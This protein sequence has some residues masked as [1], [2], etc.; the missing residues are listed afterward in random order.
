MMKRSDVQEAVL[1][2]YLRLNGYFTTGFI[3]QAPEWGRNRAQVDAL[4]I[5]HPFNSEPERVVDYST[6]LGLGNHVSDV[7]ICEV[8]SKG[9]GLQFNEGLRTIGALTTVL[10][11]VGLFSEE[12]L[13]PH[14]EELLELM[15]PGC[16]AERAQ[17]GV[18]VKGM[19]RI[20]PLLCAPERAHARANQPWFLPGSVIFNWVTNC[21][22]PP[23]PRSSCA[24]Q[25]DFTSWGPWLEPVV[26]YFKGLPPGS[27]GT[28]VDLYTEVGYQRQAGVTD[29]G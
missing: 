4:A 8:K 10:R 28:M 27:S 21:L 12:E 25:Y 22:N 3:V 18:D 24:T 23:S 9:M 19:V 29:D 7:L 14:A 15:Q 2:L 26:R 5:R 11:W 13:E 17:S 20:R 6:F 16:P 1:Q